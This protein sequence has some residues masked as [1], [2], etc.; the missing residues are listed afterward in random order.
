MTIGELKSTCPSKT[1]LAKFTATA[2]AIFLKEKYVNIPLSTP[3][4]MDIKARPLE[5]AMPY[6]TL[7]AST[8]HKFVSGLLVEATSSLAGR[9]KNDSLLNFRHVQC[10]WG[11]KRNKC[12]VLDLTS[13]LV[14]RLKCTI[15]EGYTSRDGTPCLATLRCQRRS[16]FSPLD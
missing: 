8:L 1:K 16:L 10:R 7:I 13:V 3:D 11:R 4:L 14:S 2:N 15:P 6:Q 12:E 5:E 9:A